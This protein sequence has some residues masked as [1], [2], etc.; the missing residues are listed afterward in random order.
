MEWWQER[1]SNLYLDAGKAAWR[2][3]QLGQKDEWVWQR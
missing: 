1:V 3:H 2:K